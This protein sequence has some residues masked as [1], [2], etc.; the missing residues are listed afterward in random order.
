MPL[1]VDAHFCPC[2]SVCGMGGGEEEGGMGIHF[3]YSGS[4]FY[5]DMVTTIVKVSEEKEKTM[6]NFY[7]CT[8]ISDNT[9]QFILQTF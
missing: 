5:L 8:Y 6:K 2:M 1:D 4:I 7:F 3:F 9:S